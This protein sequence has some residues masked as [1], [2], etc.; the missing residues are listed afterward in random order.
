MSLTN[1]AYCSLDDMQSLFSSAGVTAFAD[2]D[3][4]G[5]DDDGVTDHCINRAT[6]E[7]NQYLSRWHSA[8]V[9]AASVLVNEWATVLAVVYLCRR[10]GNPVPESLQEDYAEIIATLKEAAAGSGLQGLA[11]RSDL[12]PTMSNL[13]VDRRYPHSTIRVTREN[14]TDAPTVLSQDQVVSPVIPYE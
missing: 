9:L 8:T 2:H 6:A 3:G 11:M 10:R 7:I 1:P 5:Q 12:R 14:S 13:Q 4:D